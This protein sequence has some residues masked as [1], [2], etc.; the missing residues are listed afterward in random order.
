MAVT[1][2]WTAALNA[3]RGDT[4]DTRETRTARYTVLWG[5]YLNDV[6]DSLVNDMAETYKAQ[7]NLY[8]NIAGLYNPVGRLTD[9]YVAKVAGGTLDVT[10]QAG[11]LPIVAPR[12]QTRAAI[13]QIWGWSQWG[14]NKNL[15]VRYAAAMGDSVLKVVSMGQQVQIEVHHPGDLVEADFDRNG[16]VV[17][18]VWE[19]K[20]EERNEQG[21]KMTYTYKEV[22]TP[23][24]F[25]TYK[26]GK[27]FDY[28]SRQEAGP[29]SQYENVYGFVPCVVTRH[30]SVGQAWGMP[31]FANVIEKVDDV[32][33]L[34]SHLGDQIRKAVHPQWVSYGTRAGSGMERSDKI[35]HHPDPNGKVEALVEDI[36]IADVTGE[37]QNRLREIEQ[38]CPELKIYQL[39]GSDLSGRALRLMMGD[40]VDRVTEA[41]GQYDHALVAAN[42]MALQIGA[43]MGL[44]PAGDF[45]HSIGEREILPVD[46]SEELSLE[47][48]RLTVEQQRA[49][50][51]GS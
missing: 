37:I 21:R 48:Q 51:T 18:A 30:K 2:G 34:A 25:S 5:F 27:P 15:W 3:W 41:R 38:D 45:S 7:R 28:I 49:L 1:S 13:M 32:N 12:A 14:L 17:Y 36:N 46:E 20:A 42:T 11:A 8:T 39:S 19:Y 44:W 50:L 33:D 24:L 10:G 16:N 31:S 43:E 9:F 4:V 29:L 26:N 47:I 6:Y 22:A 40:V 23:T 35:W